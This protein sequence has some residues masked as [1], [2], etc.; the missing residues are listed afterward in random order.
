M[1]LIDE[2][3][4][5]YDNTAISCELS[6]NLSLVPQFSS[7]NQPHNEKY[8]SQGKAGWAD[9]EAANATSCI[10]YYHDERETILMTPF[11]LEEEESYGLFNMLENLDDVHTIFQKPAYIP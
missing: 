8:L 9:D 1:K 3:V 7:K 11:G 5:A 10:V 4:S 2:R 6:S